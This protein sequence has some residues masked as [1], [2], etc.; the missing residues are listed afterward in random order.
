MVFLYLLLLIMAWHILL[1]LVTVLIRLILK[2]IIWLVICSL[3]PQLMIWWLLWWCVWIVLWPFFIETVEFTWY[4]SLW[5]NSLL[6]W[7]W[8]CW[9]STMFISTVLTR[10]C[11]FPNLKRV[12]IRD[13][14][15]SI[16]HRCPWRR[17][18]KYPWCLLPWEWRAM[19]VGE[20][21]RGQY[22]LYLYRII[23]L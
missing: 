18:F 17:M 2:Y 22:F 8:I 12:Q 5:V 3:I 1:Y 21:S 19:I 14:C 16:R 23:Y 13:S 9:S 15:P 7:E 11:C 6:F 4:V 20:S 10:P